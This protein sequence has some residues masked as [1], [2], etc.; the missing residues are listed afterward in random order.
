MGSGTGECRFIALFARVD[1]R[2]STGGR[3]GLT[4]GRAARI[5]SS[6]ELTAV[7]RAAIC[8]CLAG[9][10]RILG[11]GQY[12]SLETTGTGID[13]AV[14]VRATGL[15]GVFTEGARV[16]L[17]VV[18]GIETTVRSTGV[19]DAITAELSQAARTTAVICERDYCPTPVRAAF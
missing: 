10:T 18:V 5:G 15:G 12:P 8:V 19:N 4:L 1:D 3:N 16:T 7:R 17:F 9:K 13:D 11:T 6:V 2:V 14:T